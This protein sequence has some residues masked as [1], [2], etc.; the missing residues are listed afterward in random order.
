MMSRILSAA[1]LVAS[2]TLPST[3]EEKEATKL[4]VRAASYR[5]IPRE[6]KSLAGT[7]GSGNTTC[8]GSGSGAGY[9]AAMNMNCQTVVTPPSAP[10]LTV[11]SVEIFNIVET[12]QM[13]YT[14]KCEAKWA[15]ADC[16]WL[17]PGENFPAELKDKTMWVAM[18]RGRNLGRRERAKYR[19][20]DARPKQ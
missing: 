8:Y 16:T 17:T 15:G 12:H 5:A 11:K 20:V 19:I 2:L 7:P 18:R 10:P 6:T 14:I 13:M 1:A 9:W 4:W 3:A